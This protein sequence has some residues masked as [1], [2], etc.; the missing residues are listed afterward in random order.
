MWEGTRYWEEPRVQHESDEN[1]WEALGSGTAL[2]RVAEPE[3]IAQVILFL[4]SSLASY[5]T[6]AEVV[7]DGSP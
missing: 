1:A 4:A 6:G 3:E 2:G 7:V 5:M